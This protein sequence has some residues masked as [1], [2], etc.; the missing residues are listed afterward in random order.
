MKVALCFLISYEHRLNKD[1][2]WREWIEPNSDIIEVIVHYKE[3]E[4]IQSE[5]LK[6]YTLPEN[7]IVPTDYLHVV[8]AYYALMMYGLQEKS[9]HIQWFCFLTEACVPIISPS[10]F[11]ELFFENYAT[12]MMSWRKAWW[13]VYIH[14][15]ANLHLL[16]PAFHLGHN[17]WFV[18]SRSNAEA[19][20][21]FARKYKTTYKTICNG[22]IANESLFAI[23]LFSMYTLNTVKNQETMATDWTRM[24]SATSPYLFTTGGAKDR[25][26]ITDFIK[27]NKYTMFLRKVDP[28]FPDSVLQDYIRENEEMVPKKYTKRILRFIYEKKVIYTHFFETMDPVWKY[29]LGFSAVVGILFSIAVV[30]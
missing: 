11:R 8:P 15:R 14:K 24:M 28:S 5:W 25:A 26:F 16:D 13:N 4:K 30:L 6:Q 9:K 29:A 7:C 23:A 3:K 19:C 17:A 20:I 21:A 1:Q 2:I 12:T 27:K 18:L 22:S 10:R